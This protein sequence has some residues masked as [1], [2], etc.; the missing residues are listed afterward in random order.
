MRTPAMLWPCVAIFLIVGLY[1]TEKG[2]GYLILWVV[3][4]GW[5]L[6]SFVRT[7]HA[8]VTKFVLDKLGFA[9]RAART[10]SRKSEAFIARSLTKKLEP[11][12]ANG[13]TLVLVG[14]DGYAIYANEPHPILRY[15][16]RPYPWRRHVEQLL[17][18][19]CNIVQYIVSP[20][21]AAMAAFGELEQGSF[22][23][24][25]ACVE[26][27]RQ[28]GSLE[29]RVLRLPSNNRNDA[30]GARLIKGLATQHPSFAVSKDGKQRMM[31]LERYHAPL[32]TTAIG[33]EYYSPSDLRLCPEPYERYGRV[34]ARA[35]A[36]TQGHALSDLDDRDLLQSDWATVNGGASVD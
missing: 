26:P 25:D 2:A 19:G 1:A 12:L 13:G 34:V 31:W 35:W 20:T 6:A 9:E 36:L 30:E 33:C 27:G 18:N 5:L 24:V 21:E 4:A 7:Q 22:M 23:Y 32:S 14:G 15:R 11:V 28:R 10:P 16:K 3:P 17:V 8:N 29:V